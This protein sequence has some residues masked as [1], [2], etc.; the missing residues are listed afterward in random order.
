MPFL[1]CGQFTPLH[2]GVWAACTEN[3]YYIQYFFFQRSTVTVS[4]LIELHEMSLCNI[5]IKF[6]LKKKTEQCDA[7]G[8][9][10][11][12][13][14]HHNAHQ[15]LHCNAAAGVIAPLQDLNFRSQKRTFWSCD[16]LSLWSYVRKFSLIGNC[17]WQRSHCAGSMQWV[18]C[19]HR[20]AVPRGH[21]CA[22]T[23]C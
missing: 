22:G 10:P 8:W 17:P 2:C 12:H 23:W 5:L 4:R 6:I 11:P 7:P 15:Q 3:K 18:G 20:K 13:C 14:L 9:A 16:W 1:R 19:E 21:I